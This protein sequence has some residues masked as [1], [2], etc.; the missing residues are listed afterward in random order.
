MISSPDANSAGDRHAKLLSKGV[1]CLY[2]AVEILPGILDVWKRGARVGPKCDGSLGEPS[3]PAASKEAFDDLPS[4]LGRSKHGGKSVNASKAFLASGYL[5]SRLYML[6]PF[7]YGCIHLNIRNLLRLDYGEAADED[8]TAM[9]PTL[10]I[11][12]SGHAS[13]LVWDFRWPSVSPAPWGF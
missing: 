5:S 7:A 11:D 3:S 9:S 1:S 4:T 6:D 12:A 13:V 8:R 2:E 10:R